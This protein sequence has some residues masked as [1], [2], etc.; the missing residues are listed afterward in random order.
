MEF[1][2]QQTSRG[3]QTF[4]NKTYT[5]ELGLM[6]DFEST[7]VVPKYEDHYI[8]CVFLN[9]LF[10]ILFKGDSDGNSLYCLAKNSNITGFSTC[11]TTFTKNAA[12]Y[13][14]FCG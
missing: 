12:K 5:Y 13:L 9:R 2:L 3:Y 10:S 7:F 1:E 11:I 8:V 6:A 4:K 14:S